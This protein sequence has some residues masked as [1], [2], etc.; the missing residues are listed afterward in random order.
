[1]AIL[2]IVVSPQIKKEHYES[3]RKEVDW[4]HRQPDGMVFHAASF[5]AA[6]GIRV[7]DVWESQE[8]MDAFFN[9]RLI[10]AMRKLNI[11]PPT[12]KDIYPLHAAVAH[13]GIMQYRAKQVS[14]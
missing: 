13:E 8:T 5:D 4:E 11:P 14:R 3:L 10:P 1:M 7:A 6:G 9:T 12:S 2:M